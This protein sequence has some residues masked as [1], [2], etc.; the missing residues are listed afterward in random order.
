MAVSRVIYLLFA[1]CFVNSVSSFPSV[2]AAPARTCS[3]QSL[4]QLGDSIS[5][6]GNLIR[7]GVAGSRS[8]CGRLPYGQT[9]FGKPTGRCSDG[10]LMIDHVAN[11]LQLPMLEP[12]LNPHAKTDHGVNFAVA[13]STA[14]NSS[15][16]SQRNLHV[17]VTNSPL[18]TQLSWFNDHL[19]RVCHNQASC[20]ER[21]EHA[22]VFV[23]EIGG[24]DYNAGSFQHKTVAEIRTYVPSVVRAVTN[25][26][27]EVIR[28][29]AHRIVVPGNFPVGCFPIYLNAFPTTDPKAY[30]DMKCLKR[31]NRFAQFHNNYLQMALNNLQ[32]ENPDV[33]ILYGDYY[34]AF[35]SVLRRAPSLGFDET[36]TLK[37]CC[38]VGGSYNFDMARMCGAQGVPV[39]ANPARSISWDGIHLTQEA[40]RHMAEWL[41]ADLLPKM[42]CN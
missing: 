42:K 1:L 17:P 19:H 25:A 30:D 18:S 34:T 13:G 20:V 4:Y 27:R 2:S 38:G 21:L 35:Q 7:V 8:S 36:S 10:L 14:L 5:D 9:F 29:G 32:K 33:V 39:C 11:S 16:F 31:L 23:G 40:Y 24:N 3:F 28:L 6:V 15:F 22:L 12:H 37:A 41:L 26:V